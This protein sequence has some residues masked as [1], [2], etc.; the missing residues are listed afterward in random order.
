VLNTGVDVVL[1]WNFWSR[2]RR[3]DAKER[4]DVAG[5]DVLL[6]WID[7][8]L[9]VVVDRARRRLA[10][11]PQLAHVIDEAAVRHFVTIF[12]PPGADEALQVV[13]HE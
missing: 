6:H 7:V 12:E 11:Q 10:A 5:Y 4:A 3:R 8:P 1:D 2:Q 13:R 9:E